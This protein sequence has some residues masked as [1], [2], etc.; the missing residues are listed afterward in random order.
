MPIPPGLEERMAELRAS[1][2]ERLDSKLDELRDAVESARD[3]DSSRDRA[4]RLAH[5]LHGTAGAYGFGDVG[6]IAGALEAALRR[7]AN[8][9]GAWRTVEGAMAELTAR[10]PSGA[11][12]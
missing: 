11:R 12:G 5:R 1:Y 9:P 6:V 10:S 8:E 4:E 3:D 2:A 7:A